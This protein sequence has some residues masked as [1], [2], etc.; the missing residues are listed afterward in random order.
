MM[1][2]STPFDVLFMIHCIGMTKKA[3]RIARLKD[4]A[5]LRKATGPVELGLLIGRKA[6]QTSD[7]LRG[8]ASF[9][10]KLARSIE[11]FAGLPERWLDSDD[12]S[13]VWPFS[14]ELLAAARRLDPV[15]LLHAENVVRAHLGMPVLPKPLRENDQKKKPP[16]YPDPSPD[17]VQRAYEYAQH[18]KT[19]VGGTSGSSKSRRVSVKRSNRRA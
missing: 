7:L 9:G 12:G 13:Q 16:A 8:T 1:S 6:N 2:L 5:A 10:E 18:G 17:E 4:F 14:A 11:E 15:A 19:A 3:T